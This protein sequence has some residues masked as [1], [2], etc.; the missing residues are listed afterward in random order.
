M[1]SI[2]KDHRVWNM[3]AILL[4]FYG[5]YL[6]FQS[7]YNGA[8]EEYISLALILFAL[9]VLQAYRSDELLKGLS[10]FSRI[11]GFAGLFTIIAVLKAELI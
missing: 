5:E 1:I 9:C 6:W 10:A 4:W 8:R 2:I 7:G 3:L 11:F